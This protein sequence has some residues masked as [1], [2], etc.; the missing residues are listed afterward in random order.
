[1]HLSFL[2]GTGTVTGSK[3]LLE[4]GGEPGGQRL[5]V[6]CGLFQGL[7]QL[8]LRNWEA[9]PLP[10]ADIGAVL[11]THAHLDHSG[12]VPRLVKLGFKGRVHATAA[13]RDLCELLLPDS[14]YLLEEDA[15]YANRHGVSR[16]HP[17]LPLYD[18]ADA[19]RALDHFT[20]QALHTAFEPLAGVQ[21]RF[22][23]AGHLLGAAQPAHRMAGTD[24]PVLRR[25]RPQ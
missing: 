14:G 20:E 7:K 4:Q 21:A 5:L 22:S 6:D 10:A 15:Q 1:M 12:S 17:A 19:R 9:L 11:L 3:A 13:T 2:G 18:E 23:S 16:H 8:R 24:D 25:H